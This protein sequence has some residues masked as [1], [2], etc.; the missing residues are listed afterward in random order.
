MSTSPPSKK[1]AFTKLK[2]NLQDIF[3]IGVIGFLFICFKLKVSFYK[4]CC[5]YFVFSVTE[6]Q[7]C[8]YTCALT[9]GQF[10]NL[11]F[12]LSLI[13][14]VLIKIA[15]SIKRLISLWDEKLQK[16]CL[17]SQSSLPLNCNIMSNIEGFGFLLGSKSCSISSF[18]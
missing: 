5:F 12:Y 17:Q 15:F 16:G 2:E 11:C 7:A 6:I 1:K 10:A 3:S 14:N 4:K 13:K 18:I 8:T 9:R